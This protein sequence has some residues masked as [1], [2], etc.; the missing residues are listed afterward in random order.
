MTTFSTTELE[1]YEVLRLVKRYHN[2][3][4][5]EDQARLVK[6]WSDDMTGVDEVEESFDADIKN[7]VGPGHL[8]SFLIH[9]FEW[10]PDEAERNDPNPD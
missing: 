5:P 6:A 4:A 8:L 2:T 3:L 9:W 1:P 7:D 10:A